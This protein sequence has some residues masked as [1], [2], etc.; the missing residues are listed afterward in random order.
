M[1]DGKYILV[2]NTADIV[3]ASGSLWPLWSDGFCVF[4]L[5]NLSDKNDIAK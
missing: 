3:N 5:F 4:I 1:Y 2:G